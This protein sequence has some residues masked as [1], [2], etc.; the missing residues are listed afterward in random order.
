MHPISESSVAMHFEKNIYNLWKKNML[1]NI[2]VW[3]ISHTDHT[4]GLIGR[5]TK[6]NV[7]HDCYNYLKK[8]I[9]RLD[10]EFFTWN[11]YKT[12]NK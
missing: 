7:R 11:F 12:K 2:F 4:I 3:K 9:K 5:A 1:F 10:F 8:K 6:G